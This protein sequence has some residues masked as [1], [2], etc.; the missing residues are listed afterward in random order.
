[1]CILRLLPSKYHGAR[2]IVMSTKDIQLN[3]CQ[4]LLLDVENSDA[5]R[6]VNTLGS[7]GG[8]VEDDEEDGHTGSSNTSTSSGSDGDGGD[9]A[10]DEDDGHTGRSDTPTNTSPIH[11]TPTVDVDGD[12]DDDADEYRICSPQ[13]GDSVEV[14]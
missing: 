11:G 5:E 7:K 1:M 6:I 10:D 9:D 12:D 3:A 13:I 14:F 2:T 8:P 4:E